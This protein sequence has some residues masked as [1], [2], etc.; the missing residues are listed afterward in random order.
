MM[1]SPVPN[2]R[3]RRALERDW[4]LLYGYGVFET[5]RVYQEMPFGLDRHVERMI[6]SAK[7]LEIGLMQ[8]IQQITARAMAYARRVHD[9]LMRMTLTAGNPELGIPARLLLTARRATYMPADQRAGIAVTFASSRRN[10]L[11]PLARHKTLNQLENMLEFQAAARRGYREAVFL[12]TAGN[13]AEGTRSNVFLVQ[14]GELVTPSL[15]CGI[16]PGVT[17]QYVLDIARRLGVVVR[18]RPVTK[19]EFLTCD[20]CFLTNAHMEV[21]PIAGIDRRET[22]VIGS[23]T[24]TAD[25]GEA[26]RQEVLASLGECAARRR[27]LGHARR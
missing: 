17:R 18:E 24:I 1:T 3:D 2:V 22:P 12:N 15:A 7:D 20:E 5:I 13:V 10:E 6:A 14:G 21:M 27:R 11:N 9:G 16:L 4:G 8:S 23:A 25:I 19:Q 26:Y